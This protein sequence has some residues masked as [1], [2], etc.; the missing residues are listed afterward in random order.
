M[1]NTAIDMEPWSAVSLLGGHQVRVRCQDGPPDPSRPCAVTVHGMADTS[2]AWMPLID[3]LRGRFQVFCLDMPWSGRDGIDW[4]FAASPER[5][6][7]EAISLI[8]V[9]PRLLIGHSFGASIILDWL[10]SGRQLPENPP[11]GVILLAPY[12]KPAPTDF[13]W[14]ILDHY[15]NRFHELLADGIRLRFPPGRYLSNDLHSMALVVRER[16]APVGW[17]EFFRLFLRSPA[18]ALD[19]LTMPALIL[20]GDR[21]ISVATDDL[22]ALGTRWPHAEVGIL[23]DCGHY[24]LLERPEPVNRLIQDWLNRYFPEGRPSSS[25]A[26]PQ[27][28]GICH[29]PNR[30]F[31][32][33]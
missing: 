13:D 17:M 30:A 23:T 6:W 5:W 27:P 21:D 32:A 9:S 28:S 16:I 20:G 10:A 7:R 22:H 18:L 15:V 1:V 3:T 2:A 33:S 26:Y 24:C 11:D 8:P 29:D 19:M 25:V 31:V 4:P 12:F 14:S